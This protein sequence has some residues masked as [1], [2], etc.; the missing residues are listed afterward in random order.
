MRRVPG[1]ARTAS[2]SGARPDAC[3]SRWATVAPGGPAGSSQAVVPSST[4]THT[5]KAVSTFVTDAQANGPVI[6]SSRLGD[7]G[8]SPADTGGR[9]RRRAGDSA[10]GGRHAPMP[11]SGQPRAR[12]SAPRL[13]SISRM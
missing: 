5:A 6:R 1:A 9:R 7:S 4:A 10:E 11:V 8:R 13:A 2:L 12:F 3:A